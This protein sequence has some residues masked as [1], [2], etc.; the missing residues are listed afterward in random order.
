MVP[1]DSINEH[2]DGCLTSSSG[3]PSGLASKLKQKKDWAD[4]FHSK[5]PS[6]SKRGKG[7]EKSV[8]STYTVSRSDISDLVK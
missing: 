7:K 2:L 1:S 4:V 3:G 6:T 5:E 8:C